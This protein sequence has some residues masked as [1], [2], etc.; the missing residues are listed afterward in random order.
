[1]SERHPHS[2]HRLIAR[3]VARHK[4]SHIIGWCALL[5]CMPRIMQLTQTFE[6]VMAGLI[7]WIVGKVAYH[8]TL[9]AVARLA[10]AYR[11]TM[12]T[13]TR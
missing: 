7:A 4:L 2:M 1:M 6:V 5:L 9:L 8:L 12:R 13:I 3:W 11:L 10:F